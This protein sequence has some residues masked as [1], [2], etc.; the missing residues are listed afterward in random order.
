M[1]VAM[2]VPNLT[3]KQ[4]GEIHKIWEEF[5]REGSPKV[6]DVKTLYT[7]VKND[8]LGLHKVAVKL[9]WLRHFPYTKLLWKALHL[10]HVGDAGF[11]PMKL[12]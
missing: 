1:H 7:S 6:V 12:S 2:I 11:N 9:S 10:V 5:I 3:A 8:G 4:I